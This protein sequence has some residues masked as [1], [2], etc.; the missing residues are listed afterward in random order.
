MKPTNESG[1]LYLV[2]PWH[3][4]VMAILTVASWLVL[5]GAVY[6][7]VITHQED[8]DRRIEALERK[9]VVLESENEKWRGQTTT[10]LERIEDKLDR[11][12]ETQHR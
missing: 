10:R 6:G 5:I 4:I 12:M 1:R 8:S 7:K 3:I 2:R 9:P 11:H